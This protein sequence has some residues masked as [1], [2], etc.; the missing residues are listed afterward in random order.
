MFSNRMVK[1]M[2]HTPPSLGIKQGV[3]TTDVLAIP[4]DETQKSV[5]IPKDKEVT[6]SEQDVSVK[7]PGK[8]SI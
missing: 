8:G 6:P 7:N 2:S 3:C 4:T 1:V 5:N